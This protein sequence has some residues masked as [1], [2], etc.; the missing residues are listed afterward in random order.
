MKD[1][2]VTINDVAKAAGVSVSTVTH[3]LNGKRPVSK[4]NKEKI[5]RVIE[6]LG[7][8]PSYSASHLRKG[9]S[10]IVGFFAVDITEDFSSKILKGA[11]RGLSEDNL[12]M[13]IAS[14][15]EFGS[16]YVKARKYF[17]RY[18]VEGMIVCHHL[19][20]DA[21]SDASSLAEFSKTGLPVVFINNHVPKETSVLPDN[22][23]AGRI[24]AEHLLKQGA[25]HLAFLGGPKSRL[26]TKY[27]YEGYK[28]AIVEQN[29][30]L[31]TGCVLY[32]D[33][34]YQSGYTLAE[35]LFSLHP[36][37]DGIFCA[38]DYIAAGAMTYAQSIGKLCPRDVKIVGCD[39]RDFSLFWSTP[40]TTIELP[41]EEMGS[42]AMRLLK[43]MLEDE[44]ESPESVLL[45]PG[46]ITRKSSLTCDR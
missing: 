36:D 40:I 29:G 37:V 17:Q 12:S 44:V 5:L 22:H 31:P 45:K 6:E 20:V 33:Y 41:L 2:N 15:E 21:T 43:E 16:D 32:G 9:R 18:G 3:A 34:T 39:N 23:Y 24:A 4:E 28:Q 42:T 26:S 8:I 35:K 25:M 11:E 10:G 7:Y 46:L 30:K 38:N 27:R 14:G 1:G 19:S 13:I